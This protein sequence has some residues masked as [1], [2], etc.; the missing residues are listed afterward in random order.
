VNDRLRWPTL[1]LASEMTLNLLVLGN[2]HGAVRILVTLWFLLACTGMSFVPLLRLPSTAIQAVVAVLL[3]IVLDTL[4][5]TA[6]VEVGGLSTNSGLI[7]L[8][9]ICLAGCTLQL[10]PWAREAGLRS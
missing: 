8:E 3:S 4:V 9:T 10:L 5:A 6:I 1:I 2:V 7:A